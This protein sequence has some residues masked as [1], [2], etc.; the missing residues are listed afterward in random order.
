MK[1][2]IIRNSAINARRL[3]TDDG[4]VSAYTDDGCN[5]LLSDIRVINDIGWH[6]QSDIGWHGGLTAEEVFIQH[7]G[8]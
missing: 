7:F 8:N 4:K 1:T 2:E 5:Q 6:Q 3:S